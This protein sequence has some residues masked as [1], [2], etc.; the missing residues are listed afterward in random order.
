MAQGSWLM[1]KGD[2]PGPE[3]RG[4]AGPGPG[5]TTLRSD[6]RSQ[7]GRDWTKMHLSLPGE[8][9]SRGN[10]ASWRNDNYFWLGSGGA[11][12]PQNRYANQQTP[13]GAGVHTPS[14]RT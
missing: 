5:N 10:V 8:G 14:F 13:K 2:R 9:K 11:A 1:A 4:H 12:H 6:R 7:A 3:A